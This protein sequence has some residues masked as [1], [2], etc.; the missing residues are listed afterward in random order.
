MNALR[1]LTQLPLLPQVGPTG[2]PPPQSLRFLVSDTTNSP[3]L[4]EVTLSSSIQGVSFS[5]SS[6]SLHFNPF[7]LQIAAQSS[8]PVKGNSP[9]LQKSAPSAI[10]TGIFHTDL[11]G[12]CHSLMT[13][14]YI[15]LISISFPLNCKSSIIDIWH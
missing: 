2:H 7:T 8:V 13:S 14:V 5:P 11:Q 1:Q 6:F 15:H 4:Q 12:Q 10:D 3:H 9:D